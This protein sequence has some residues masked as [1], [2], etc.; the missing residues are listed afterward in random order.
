MHSQ[1][2]NYL[3][4]IAGL[5]GTGKSTV[6][7]AFVVRYGGVHIN[8]DLLRNAMQLRGHYDPSDKEKVYQTMLDST[9]GALMD[10]RSAVVDSTFISN[11]IRE[12]FEAI[13]KEC[14]VPFFWVEMHAEEECLQERLSKLRP[15]SEADFGIYLALRDIQ[16]KIIGPHLELWS[17]KLSLEDMVESIHNYTSKTS[18]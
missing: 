5:P 4:L 17:D 6:A 1:A 8:S 14:K 3:L 15:D 12:N 11:R 18:L 16:E 9:K 13:A 2:T 10:N 7:K